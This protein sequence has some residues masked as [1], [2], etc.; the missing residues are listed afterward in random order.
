MY[1]V[2]VAYDHTQGHTRFCWD[3]LDELPANHRGLYLKQHTRLT[4][5]KYPC[6]WQD[7]NR[8]SQ[9]ASKQLQAYVLQHMATGINSVDTYVQ[10]KQRLRDKNAGGKC[11]W[12][13]NSQIRKIFNNLQMDFSMWP[14][15]SL[16]DTMS[17]PQIKCGITMTRRAIFLKI[18]DAITDFSLRHKSNIR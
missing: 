9:Q 17:D 13:K 11:I 2:I 18:K 5:D 10:W 6:P 4:R 16:V 8:Q 14:N 12:D 7:S 15:F 1:S 3:F